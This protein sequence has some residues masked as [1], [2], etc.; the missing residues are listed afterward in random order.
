MRTNAFTTR[1]AGCASYRA[2]YDGLAALVADT[3]LHVHKENNIL[4]PTAI[5]HERR[6]KSGTPE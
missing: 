2:L 6:L 4:F 3:H 1:G 5:E